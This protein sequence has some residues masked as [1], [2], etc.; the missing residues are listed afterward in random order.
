MRAA[1]LPAEAAYIR[2]E[3]LPGDEPAVVFVPGSYLA[4]IA[5]FV[6]TAA[7]PDLSHRRRVRVDLLG[8]GFSDRPATFGYGIGDDADT[9]AS[10]LDEANVKAAVVVGHSFG[11]AV[12][13][14]LASA[15]PD[16]V[17]RLVLVEANLDPGGGP[18][19]RFVTGFSEE[20]Y[21]STGHAALLADL[22]RA[23]EGDP[24][25]PV[26]TG[27]FAAADA[28]AL[29]R[30]CVSVA[31]DVSPTIREV[32]YGP[33]IPRLYVFGERSLPDDDYGTLP[34]HGI[35]VAVIPDAGHAMAQENPLGL[36]RAVSGFL[37]A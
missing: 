16:L 29:H 27:L 18:L 20:E 23:A 10:L 26:A 33:D 14:M 31:A 12:A 1:Y 15:R 2:Y 3:D 32:L 21:V 13:I 34:A 36:A 4:G 35:A 19:T 37:E 7:S 24:G 11:G 22:R 6:P 25:A 17:G 8:G 5:A 30:S 28:R 9:L